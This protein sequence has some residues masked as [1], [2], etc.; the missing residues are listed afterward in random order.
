MTVFEP[1]VRLEASR[2]RD[3]GGSGLGI[4]MARS[5]LRGHGGDVRLENRADGGLRVTATLPGTEQ[6]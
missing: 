6:P 5:I 4:A 3:T 2:S 1:F